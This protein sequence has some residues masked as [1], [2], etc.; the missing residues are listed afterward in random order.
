MKTLNILSLAAG[1]L[2]L[3]SSPS[4]AITFLGEE[5]IV[6]QIIYG[7]IAY[8]FLVIP[9]LRIN[10]TLGLIVFLCFPGLLWLQATMAM[11]NWDGTNPREQT[12]YTYNRDYHISRTEEER[13]A[14]VAPSTCTYSSTCQR[15]FANCRNHN[16]CEGPFAVV[17][18]QRR[19]ELAANPHAFDHNKHCSYSTSYYQP[20][21]SC[22]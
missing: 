19:R 10:R 1:G 6:S 4:Y 22:W 16:L 17:Y 11:F 9:C 18:E 8:F 21:M 12:I 13:V 3:C 20:D 15:Q 5:P 7:F 2:L 14:N